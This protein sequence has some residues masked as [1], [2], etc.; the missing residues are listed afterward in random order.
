LLAFIQSRL[1]A[2]S[3]FVTQLLDAAVVVPLHPELHAASAVADLLRHLRR[4]LAV[5][6]QRNRVQANDHFRIG[7]RP[8]QRSQLLETVMFHHVHDA[9]S[10]PTDP[11]IMPKNPRWRACAQSKSGSRIIQ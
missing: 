6:G 4:R 3:P 10:L 9:A 5:L 7:I 8:R 1:A 11:N 2:L